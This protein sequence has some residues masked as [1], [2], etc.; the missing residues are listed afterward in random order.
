MRLGKSAG[1]GVA[2]S[3]K[4]LKLIVDGIAA[5]VVLS[6][7]GWGFYCAVRVLIEFPGMRLGAAVWFLFLAS[8]Y[9]LLKR[10][11]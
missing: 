2:D 5:C 8:C 3:V 7:L 9:R 10:W 4:F 6:V 11:S 1:R